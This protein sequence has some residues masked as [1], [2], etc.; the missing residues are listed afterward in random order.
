MFFL[1][2]VFLRT[3]LKFSWDTLGALEAHLGVPLIH[4]LNSFRV[5]LGI[6][7][8]PTGGLPKVV[9][10]KSSQVSD[11]EFDEVG[12]TSFALVRCR[13]RYDTDA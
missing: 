1:H 5:V 10:Y 4:F 2:F 3:V 13:G 11:D 12:L 8:D 6:S 9:C 7:L